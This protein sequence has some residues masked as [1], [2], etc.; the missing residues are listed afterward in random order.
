MGVKCV[1]EVGF[2]L[3][4]LKRQKDNL[5]ARLD[6]EWIAERSEADLPARAF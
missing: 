6:R 3:R 2:F 4:S 5:A 1:F